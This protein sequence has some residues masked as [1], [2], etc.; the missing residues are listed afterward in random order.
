MSL[1]LDMKS[2]IAFLALGIVIAILLSLLPIYPLW[3]EGRQF[4]QTG[5]SLYHEWQFVS[6]SGYYEYTQY[7]R[8]AWSEST[9]VA[10]VLLA[11]V[12]PIVL[13]Y[14]VWLAVRALRKWITR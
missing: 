9:K 3:A 11:I 12:N 13:L 14:L 2:K 4:T 8:T 6:I 5:E 1:E 7:A 10:Y